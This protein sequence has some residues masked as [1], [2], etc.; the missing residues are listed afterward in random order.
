LV[1]VIVNRRDAEAKGEHDGKPYSGTMDVFTVT[2]NWK[3]AEV[4][5]KLP[6]PLASFGAAVADGWLYV[7]GGHIGEQH[8]HS[9]ANLSQ[10]FRRLR[11]DGGKE[12]EELPMQTPLQ[13]TALVAH[14][15][16]VF[17]IGGL[18]AKNATTETEEDMHSTAE[19]A[20]YDPAT[21]K[22]TALAPLP[23]PR[24]S[25]DA[26]FIGD[27]LYVVGGWA[28]KGSSAGEW[29]RELLVYDLAKHAA[30]QGAWEK[31]PPMASSRRAVAAGEWQGKLVVIGGIDEFGAIL[32]E[33]TF[34][35]PMTGKW[36][37]G[38]QI[39]EGDMAGFGASAW[40]VDGRLYM[41]SLPGVLF[42]L[43]EDGSKWEEA[44]QLNTPRF[45]H[46]LL[47]GA[48]PNTILAVAGSAMDGHVAEIEV[49]R[50][51]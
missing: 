26:V 46:R 42:R 49:L 31:L 1:S 39:P 45:F 33:T 5:A 9:A 25:H 30:G 15:G 32:R 50:V 13:G 8:A 18:S 7:Y 12:W 21:K 41:S 19:F 40:N 47:P 22:W 20:C 44:T 35:D 14:G 3:R 51:R 27:K 17:R 34:F 6:E 28:L 23:G 16:K 48:S 38:P 36:S 24:S 29:Q 10:H 2:F 43:S 37:D 11:L 4:F